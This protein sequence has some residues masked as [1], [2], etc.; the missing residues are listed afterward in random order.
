M[1]CEWL[2]EALKPFKA[3]K[4]EKDSNED[5]ELDKLGSEHPMPTTI[6]E[7]K[8]HPLYA[9][10]RH[11]L[12][13]EALYPPDAPPLGYLRGEPIYARECVHTLMTREKWYKEGMVVRPKEEPYRV[14]KHMKWDRATNKFLKDQPLDVFGKWQTDPYEPPT[15]ENGIV[16]RNEYGNVELFKPTMLPKKTVHLQCEYTQKS[17]KKPMKCD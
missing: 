4:S 15:A 7:F 1:E 2:E 16:P 14:L 10:S 3:E 6:T 13:F 9:L 11:F 12:K 17:P 5:K 8:N